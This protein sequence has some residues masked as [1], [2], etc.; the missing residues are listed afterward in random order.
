MPF[1]VIG[2]H[3]VNAYGISR[4]T[5]DL[6]LLVPL[7]NRAQWHALML[8][9]KFSAIQDDERF[10]RYIPPDLAAWP[11]DFMFVDDETFEKLHSESKPANIGVAETRTVSA[12]HL[13]ILKIHALNQ[14][15]SHRETKDF[16]DAFGLLR[17]GVT[18]V[19]PEELLTFCTRYANRALYDKLRPALDAEFPG[20]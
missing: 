4:Q 10:A 19:T 9:I 2:G 8:R 11:I 7:R 3:A 12:R 17:A 20:D 16:N 15:Q 6:D 5:G 18:G 1:L 14:D 13:L